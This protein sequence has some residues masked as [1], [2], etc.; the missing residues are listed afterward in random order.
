[1]SS[2]LRSNVTVAMGTAA[3]R[4]TGLIRV[5]ALG[6]V[7][8]QGPLA[9]AYNQANSTPNLV[10]ELMLGG[11]L[12]ATL[13]PLFTGL[14]DDDD[15]EGAMAV[16]SVATV[17]L[18]ALT[19]LAVIAAPWIFHAYSWVTADSV[20][21]DQYRRVGSALSR[22]FLVQILFY[23][24]NALGT[25]MLNA[26]R[27]YFAAAWAPALSNVVTIGALFLVPAA[28]DGRAPQLDDVL[29]N[30]ALRW[31]LGLGAT[32]G[33]AVMAIALLPALLSSG[34]A[35]LGFKLD[36]RHPAVT[37]FRKLSGWALGYVVANQ[38]A[39]LVVQNLTRPGGGDQDAY[40]D[41]FTWFVLPHGLLA[42][43]IATTFL[44][45]LSSAIKRRDREQ[46]IA[47][48][49]L[50]IRLVALF[51][52]P[53][54]FGLFTLRR[55]IIGAAFQ[56][57]EYS[58]A[59]AMNTSR[60]LA[61]FA[62]GLGG[63]SVYLIV[64]RVFYAHQDARTPFVINLFE[65]GLN[66]VLAV[67]LAPKFG[68][69]GLGL[70]FA[71]AYVISAAWALQVLSYKVR[72][73]PLSDVI[74]SLWRFVLASVVMSE[75]VWWVARSVGANSGN[76]SVTRTLIG[77]FAG[78]AVYVV[79]LAVLGSPELRELRQRLTPARSSS[80]AQ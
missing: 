73:F 61:G 43:S 41:A 38:A 29:R 56:H 16:A 9:D 39:I 20:D 54:G 10:Y 35:P 59:A 24:L 14:A 49:S 3:S 22:I 77:T 68:V 37:Q 63:F 1:V 75:V 8:G 46:L 44:P 6:V 55:P 26:R 34:A 28:M 57:G 13:V 52:I 40:T 50:G 60:A 70:A 76:G 65:N 53:A 67:I 27:R 80:R 21:A 69:L 12:S 72:G 23:G 18:V 47:R 15:S 2:L 19:T 45:E 51:T 64:L 62:L 32:A 42:M 78:G 11:V 33:I 31:S 7:L 74:G 30:D 5:A 4:V 71:L 36:F 66:I 48:A 79:M 17:F 58:A 25:A